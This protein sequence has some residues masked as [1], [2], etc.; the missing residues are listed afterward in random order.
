[1]SVIKLVATSRTDL[2]KG[3]S[4]RLRHTDQTPGV[5]YGAGKDPVSLTFEH[6]E[7]MKVEGI[8]AFYSSVLSLEVDGVAE[9]VLLKDIQRHSFKERI[10]H[11]DLLRVDATQAI[12]TTVPLHYLNEETAEAVKNGGVVAHLANELEVTCLPADLP[13]FIEVDIANVEIG[14][15]VHISDVT[16]PKGVESVELSKGEEHDLPLLAITVKKTAAVEE[17]TEE[18]TEADAAE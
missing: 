15:T 8:E 10:Q 1:M 13:A 7:L 17:E 3:A 2:G 5:V 4:R 18:A 16:L 9:Q 12:T 14:Q 6:K 11:L